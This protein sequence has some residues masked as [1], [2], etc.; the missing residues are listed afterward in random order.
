MARQAL[1]R[2]FSGI[3]SDHSHWRFFSMKMVGVAIVF[4]LSLSAAQAQQTGISGKVMDSQGAVIADANV[5]VKR[6][7]AAA[8]TT[9]TN[10][11]GTFLVPSLTADEYMV[12]V[13]AEGFT[14]VETKVT[15][16]VGQTAEVDTVLPV[17][18][19]SDSIIV[20]EDADVVDT[21]S[22][23]VS[24]N[25]TPDDV[26]NLPINGRNYMELATLVP[27]VRLN[28]VVNDTPLGGE[29]S[30]KFQINLDGMQVTQNTADASF[31]QPR[32]SPDA[33][34]QFQIITNRFDATTGRSEG[35]VVNVQS[36]SGA[37]AMHGSLFGYFRSDA[38]NAGDPIY[39]E[40]D[41]T[42]RA[43]IAAGTTPY[44]NP[45]LPLSDQQF[46]ATLGGAIKKDR[47]WYFGSYEGEH[48]SSGLPDTP[49]LPGA[50]ATVAP[51]TLT[52][53]EYL[54]RVDWQ[55]SA[56]D[57]VFV[58]GNGFT[59]KNNHTLAS[60]SADPSSAFIATRNNYTLL[61]DW[62]RVAG[63]KLVNDVHI[64]F[65]HFGW[66]NVP[67]LTSLAIT[68]GSVTVGAPYNYPQIFNQA[69]Q[70]YRDDLFYLIG[71]H[72]FKVGGE[73][74][75][76]ADTGLFQQNLNGTVSGCQ[77]I[78]SA[79]VAADLFPNGTS[80]P[81][82]WN[83]TNL[84]D[85]TKTD[86][87]SLCS[88]TGTFVQGSGNF[89]V[90]IPRNQIAFWAQD[91]YKVLSRLTVNMGLR[92]DN[93]FGIFN[94][95]L[96][97]TNGLLTPK[98]NDNHEFAPRVGFVYDIFGKG[99]TVI[100]GGAG[101]FF[102]DVSANQTIDGQIFNGQTSLQ[103][104]IAGSASAPL[105]LPQPAFGAVP[106]QAVQPLGPNVATPWSLQISGGVQQELPFHTVLTADYVHTRAYH[107]W[108]RLNANLLQNPTNPELSLSPNTK[109]TAA[110][111]T[112]TCPG[113]GVTQDATYTTASYNVCAQAFTNVNQFFTP[114]GAGSIYDALQLGL[115]HSVSHSFS[116]GLAYTYSR[117]KDSSESPFYYPNKPFLN[118]LHDEWANGQD[119][120]RHTL[121]ITGDYAIKYGLSL[122]GLFHFGSGDAFPTYLSTA[123]STAYSPSYNRTFQTNVVPVAAGTA[124][125]S[126]STCLTVY[127]NPANNFLDPA[128]GYYVTKRDAAYGRNIYRADTRVQEAHRFGDRFRGV[129]A[130]EA[131]NLFNHSNYGTYNGQINSPLYGSPQ[132][133]TSTAT[134]I[135][136]E[137]RPRSLQF[138]ARLEF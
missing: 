106:R 52:V 81:S 8:Y 9:R 54:G 2:A 133:T 3:C 67:V 78:T 80:S 45:V 102:A 108:V 26:K 126:G 88:T 115:R 127:N 46:G 82:T 13:M 121:T 57:H 15:M 18:G 70:E 6:V 87:D 60:G 31:G 7:G 14:T 47:L 107:D 93:D 40:Q 128:T 119:D 28:A 4:L 71:K 56:I 130:V 19:S 73:F 20:R 22:S 131:F 132:S 74:L 29:N 97:L 113:G 69:V 83:Y 23:S 49:L 122:S 55:P 123:Q 58:R 118:G 36:K 24:G 86:I 39:K 77:A 85:A 129:V 91:D 25:I 92:Y 34:S 35:L 48:Q 116:G 65:S 138:L 68:F 62:N 89:N 124:C 94:T 136:V 42:N 11:A 134:G 101:M 63:P 38:F 5:E 112:P 33:I 75:H 41:L 59:F 12:K 98:S 72:S 37:N 110:E 51:Q 64:G 76:S 117:V 44:I 32:F 103:D 84:N 95:G 96:T 120:Q 111:G 114:N 17:K 53:N 109:Y 16:L 66:T 105:L 30:G 21:T 1:G 79:A 27:G 135:P 61:G 125:P 137:F 10:S 99:K 104:S 50:A 43:A 100:R 90:N